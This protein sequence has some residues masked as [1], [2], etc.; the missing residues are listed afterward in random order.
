[1]NQKERDAFIN[2]WCDEHPLFELRVGRPK[3]LP[4]VMESCMYK[5]RQLELRDY[6]DIKGYPTGE[7]TFA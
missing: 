5:L 6:W 3:P 4:P 1:M 2:A 7:G